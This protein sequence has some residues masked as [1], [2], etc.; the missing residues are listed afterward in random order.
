MLIFGIVKA[1]RSKVHEVQR[2][3]LNQELK[4]KEAKISKLDQILWQ[5]YLLGVGV[6]SYTSAVCIRL[7]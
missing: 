2:L 6:S 5:V 7:I 3:K 1:E 4:V